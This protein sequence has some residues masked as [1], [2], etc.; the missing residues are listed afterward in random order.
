MAIKM[1]MIVVFIVLNG[2]AKEHT[3]MKMSPVIEEENRQ[4]IIYDGGITVLDCPVFVLDEDGRIKR[5]ED[6]QGTSVTKSSY[7]HN[8]KRYIAV[9]VGN[10][11]VRW[12]EH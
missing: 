11:E 1:I 5:I 2:C 9:T 12:F 7:Y 8:G 6:P 3:A 10:G 4:V